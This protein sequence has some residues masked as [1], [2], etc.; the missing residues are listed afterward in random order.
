MKL[1]ISNKNKLLIYFFYD[2]D[3]IIDQYVFFQL[4]KI[5]DFVAEILFVS[6]SKV[7]DA[8]KAKL[9][10]HVSKIIERNNKGF[11]VW[12]YKEGMEFYG[13]NKLK[14]FD[15]VIL[16]NYTMFGPIYSLDN[17]F[18]KMN[19]SDV[20]FWGV[21][22]HHQVDFDCWNTCELGY[23]PE[24]IQSS[25]IAVRRSMFTSQKFQDYWDNMCLINSYAESIG[26][27]EA[28][29]TKKFNEYGFKSD[30]YINTDDLE[31]YTRY[32][33][34]IMADEL[35]INRKCPFVKQK[36][37]SQ[38]YYDILTDSL[39]YAPYK[40][41]EYIEKHTSY[42]INFIWDSVLRKFNMA[43]IKKM[44]HLNYIL[45][46]NIM[47]SHSEI[48]EKVALIIHIYYEDLLDE[49]IKYINKMPKFADLIITTPKK[50][51]VEIINKKCS[52]LLFNRCIVLEIE[53]RGR[54]VSSLLVGAAPYINNYDLVCYMHDKKTTQIKPYANGVGFNYKCFENCLG[55]EILVYN[56]IETFRQN[57]RLG[58][59]MPPP[60]NHGNF[61]QILGS[62]WANN[63]YNTKDLLNKLDIP[64]PLYMNKEPISP[65]GTM[66]WFRP[67]T[68]KTLFDINW[69]YLDFPKEPNN[70]DGTIL[71][72][73]ERAYGIVCQYEGYYP[74]WV[75]SDDYARIEITNLN[76][77]LRELNT[78]LLN[79]Y[80]T[81]NL[82]DMTEKMKAHMDFNWDMKTILKKKVKKI[83]KKILPKPIFKLA[84]KIYC[85]IRGYE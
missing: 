59:L 49:T 24:H 75:M 31:G 20:D 6:N 14:E 76:F 28:I 62:E 19:V 26:K 79:K 17:M 21:T 27:H 78:V 63:Y 60:P 71:H 69:K 44:M 25:F 9:R 15:E 65:L 85:N 70:Y 3:N 1:D 67:K 23:I 45:P 52:E 80:F 2:Q 46:K 37:F 10:Q 55:S 47:I 54:D 53:N 61:Y 22:K 16:M 7:K 18:E 38:N 83:L 66:F 64:I 12:A 82:L 50:D 29:F 68:L 30:V 5:K 74:A 39:G 77:M 11:D 8:D 73:I 13:W 57:P 58:M 34:M 40:T 35:I 84:R 72:A 4:N 42:D 33:L 43:D 41:M 36:M 51:L 56:I 32:P 48:K 81:T